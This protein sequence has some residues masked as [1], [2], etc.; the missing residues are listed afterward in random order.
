LS[1][2]LRI[3]DR[4]AEAATG[5]APSRAAPT[6]S[7]IEPY[8]VLF[9]IGVAYALMGVGLWPATVL[10]LVPYPGAL[11]RALMMQGFEQSFVMG[12]LLTAMPAFPHGP[13]CR[14]LELGL[15]AILQLGFGA[16]ALSG[17]T[18][19]AE[20]CFVAAIALLGAAGLRRIVGNPQK[21]PEEFAFVGFGLVLGM[22]GGVVLAAEALGATPTLPPRFA[23]H[24]ISLG[25][26]LSL[27]IGVGS[28]LVPTFAGLRQPLAIP[29]VAGPHER[30]GRRTLY[31]AVIATFLLAFVAEG[32]GRAGLALVAR[33]VAATVMGSWVWKL[34]RLPRRDVPAYVLWGSGWMTILG[35]WLAAAFPAHAV[36]ALHVTFIGG[37]GLLTL[38]IGTRVVVAHGKHPLETER[39]TL[40]VVVVALVVVALAE[41]LRAELA[42]ARAVHA[43]AGSGLAWLAAWL[44]WSA[45]A[46]PRILRTHSARPAAADVGRPLAGG[47]GASPGRSAQGSTPSDA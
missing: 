30:R 24:L 37:F 41:R 9:P 22:L 23:D 17:V 8:R 6:A 33:A 38:G 13:R 12:F 47:D 42:P 7:P 19:L 20:L 4:Q 45:R 32:T 36:A 14:P 28:L 46:L 27:V 40:N 10:D 2:L 21:P 16:A 1:A 15:A 34:Y 43:L 31:A 18:W 35:L 25:M 11:H 39:R 3:V 29:G 26:V 5:G 44:L